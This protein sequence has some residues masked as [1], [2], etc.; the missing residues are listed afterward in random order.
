MKAVVLAATGPA[1]NLTLTEVARPQPTAG[2]AVIRVAA[3]G[4]C[5]R[6]IIDRRGGF[7]FM[8][9][10]VIPGHE[11]AGEVIDV[12]PGVTEVAPGDRVVNLHRA[13][14]GQCEFCTAGHEPRCSRS[15]FMFG[16]TADG[17]Y[18]EQVLAPVGCLVPLPAEVSFESGCFLA[19]TAGVALRALRTHGQVGAGQSVLITGA[20]G[21]VGLHAMQLVRALGARAIAVTSSDD[22]AAVLRGFGADDVIV[23]PDLNFHKAALSATGGVHVAIDCVGAPTLNS[24]LRSLRPTGRAVLLGNVTTERAEIN[25]GFVI[26]NELSVIGSAGCNRADL[27]QVL[28]WAA[29]GVIHPVVAERLPLEQAADAHR[30]LEQ[31]QVTGRLV[32]VP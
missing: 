26:L 25:P 19:C 2:H 22:K 23:S 1:E 7:P 9:L 12:G 18:A 15:L 14:C 30:R 17:S 13:P 29:S 6:D 31:R 21:G 10:P 5:Y 28:A 11:F 16:I 27:V 8:K 32:L 20:S 24:S 3:T 4:V